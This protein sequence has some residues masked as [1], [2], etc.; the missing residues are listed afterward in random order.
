VIENLL[1]VPRRVQPIKLLACAIDKRLINMMA[2]NK[3][4]ALIP[5]LVLNSIAADIDLICLRT[6]LKT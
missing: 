5:R 1:I 3:S 6:S 2:L 4:L